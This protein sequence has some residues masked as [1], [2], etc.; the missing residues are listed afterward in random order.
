MCKFMA[1]R[2]QFQTAKLKSVFAKYNENT[3]YFSEQLEKVI[4]QYYKFNVLY[5]SSEGNI[6]FLLK[7]P[8]TGDVISFKLYK[9]T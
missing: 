5:I 1:L 3:S 9:I 4:G 8:A 2:L 7:K 6:Y